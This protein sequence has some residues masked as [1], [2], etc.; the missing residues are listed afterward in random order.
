VCLYEP[1]QALGD[2][3]SNDEFCGD[4]SPIHHIADRNRQ[5]PREVDPL[6][7]SYK[8]TQLLLLLLLL[9]LLFVAAMIIDMII[10]PAAGS[11]HSFRLSS[12]MVIGYLAWIKARRCT[13]QVAQ[14]AS[15]FC[16]ATLT[17]LSEC[18]PG[19]LADIRTGEYLRRFAVNKC[20]YVRQ[21]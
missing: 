2:R 16:T 11:C 5:V 7:I 6:H 18:A 1:S 4:T 15:P 3:P 21:R 9:L 8:Q 13:V 10:I 12:V 17:T 14:C 20:E 19:D